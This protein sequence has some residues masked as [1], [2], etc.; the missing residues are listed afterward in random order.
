MVVVAS[1]PPL[2][3]ETLAALLFAT[4]LTTSAVVFVD[5]NPVLLYSLNVLGMLGVW[6][7]VWWWWC[8]DTPAPAIPS[9][10]W[11]QT[12]L[13]VV[14]ATLSWRGGVLAHYVVAYLTCSVILLFVHLG[15]LLGLNAYDSNTFGFTVTRLNSYGGARALAAFLPWSSAL[16]DNFV[17]YLSLLETLG[18]VVHWHLRRDPAQL[19]YHFPDAAH[20]LA[21][22]ALKTAIF[23]TVVPLERVLV[24]A[25]VAECST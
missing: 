18:M 7:V 22:T 13:F 4:A 14:Y 23:V 24:A 20:A 19:A 8:G 11:T 1:R 25:L 2:L 5:P 6:A 3:L 17:V 16:E 12:L 10:I 9:W 15:H 21:Y